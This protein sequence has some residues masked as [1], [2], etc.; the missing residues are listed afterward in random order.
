MTFLQAIKDWL[1]YDCMDETV[2]SK[3]LGTLLDIHHRYT[4]E[5]EGD[6]VKGV[7][8]LHEKLHTP[9]KTNWTIRFM[10]AQSECS[11]ALLLQSIV[12]FCFVLMITFR[13]LYRNLKEI[14]LSL[15]LQITGTASS[16][17]IDA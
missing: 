11:V 12:I 8:L 6:E 15:H 3:S 10:K 16:K 7:K 14:Q 13:N 4:V 2:G 9:D 5:E 1:S 17:V